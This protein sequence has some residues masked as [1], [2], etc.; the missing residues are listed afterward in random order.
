MEEIHATSL[1]V[2][3]PL[4]HQITSS[5]G[6]SQ[7]GHV[8]EKQICAIFPTFRIAQTKKNK[9][10]LTHVHSS[11]QLTVQMLRIGLG[12][13][14]IGKPN[15]N[16]CNRIVCLPYE[17][18]S[19]SCVNFFRRGPS[20]RLKNSLDFHLPFEN[21]HQL[22]LCASLEDRL[23]TLGSSVHVCFLKVIARRRIVMGEF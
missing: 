4:L 9:S 18:E 14:Q 21:I 6:K 20:T 2:V 3:G 5:P 8:F 7:F 1:G 15:A 12:G 19:K 11:K 22:L 13:A 10:Q 23:L 16:I 17:T